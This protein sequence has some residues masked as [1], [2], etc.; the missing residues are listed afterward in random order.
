MGNRAVITTQDNLKNDGV[1]VYLHWNG[2]RDSVEG[3]LAYCEAQEFRPPDSDNYGWARLCQVI[4][5]FFGGGLSLG[6][7]R[8]SELDC[9]NYDNGVYLIKGWEIVGR[10]FFSGLEQQCYDLADFMISVDEAQPDG[11]RLGEAAIRE[12]VS[13]NKAS[14]LDNTSVLVT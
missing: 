8:C 4:G 1:G 14:Q 9:D 6:I 5:N 12:W 10:E 13:E 7:G 11:M 2:G 3:F